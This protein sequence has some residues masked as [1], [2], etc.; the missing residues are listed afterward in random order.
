[1]AVKS[2]LRRGFFG[3][4]TGYIYLFVSSWYGELVNQI[5]SDF[6]QSVLA[7]KANRSIGL[8]NFFGGMLLGA[9]SKFLS[10]KERAN[11][12]RVS[13]VLGGMVN[14]AIGDAATIHGDCGRPNCG[15]PKIPIPNRVVQAFIDTVL[16][17]Q[18]AVIEE[19]A[20]APGA[21]AF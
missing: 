17:P 5:S 18:Q 3:I 6:S 19:L 8:D 12:T 4:R 1:M 10:T 16:R 9:L 20:L 14:P 21:G 15:R 2:K 7:T 13:L 11:G